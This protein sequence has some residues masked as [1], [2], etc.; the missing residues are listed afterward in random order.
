MCS[1]TAP[2]WCPTPALRTCPHGPV[3]WD[4]MAVWNACGVRVIPTRIPSPAVPPPLHYKP[5][6]DHTVPWDAAC[7]N[8]DETL[9][10]GRVG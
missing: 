1:A 6:D 7:A 4:C 2:R 10:N 5:P 8:G 9:D 3:C